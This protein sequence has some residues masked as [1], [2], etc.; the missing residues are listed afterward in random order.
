MLVKDLMTSPVISVKPD[1]KV[2]AIADLLHSHRFTGVPVVNDDGVVVGVI[3]ERELFSADSKLYLPG[4]MKI[5]QE[6]KFII[7]GHKELPYAAEQL[8]R[9]AAKDIMNRN[10]HFVSPD[11]SV[12]ELAELLVKQ[13]QSPIPVTDTTNK[14]LGIVSRSDL[15]GLLAPPVPLHDKTYYEQLNASLKPR[16][17]DEEL[18]Y[19]HHDLSSRFA[20]VAKAKANIWLT[21]L[22]V[23]FVVGFLVG[24]IYVANPAIIFGNRSDRSTVPSSHY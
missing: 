2:S 16:P 24:V 18:S 23:L 6:T 20:Y 12:E 3:T 17:I 11:T 22:I 14:L 9:T 1:A 7:G 5:L 4:Y 10:V 13:N 21:A 19:I 8:T 15:I